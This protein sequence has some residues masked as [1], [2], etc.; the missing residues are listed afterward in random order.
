[1]TEVLLFF[2]NLFNVQINILK[3]SVDLSAVQIDIL[4]ICFDVNAVQINVQRITSIAVQTQRV[5]TCQATLLVSAM[6]DSLETDS[7]VLVNY[8]MILLL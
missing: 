7:T 3:I 1:M 5:Q 2:L 4:S 8:Y 6:M